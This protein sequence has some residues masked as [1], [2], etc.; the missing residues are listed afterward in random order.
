[1]TRKLRAALVARIQKHAIPPFTEVT[2]GQLLTDV[3]KLMEALNEQSTYPTLKLFCDWVVHAKL[4]GKKVQKLL[5]E[6]DSLYDSRLQH[7]IEINNDMPD[8]LHNFL[9]FQGFK[10]ELHVFLG[11]N[12]SVQTPNVLDKN[13]WGDF[14]ETYCSIVSDCLLIY[15][16]KK[17]PLK[18]FDRASISLRKLQFSPAQIKYDPITVSTGVQWIFFKGEKETFRLLLMWGSKPALRDGLLPHSAPQTP[19][20][21]PG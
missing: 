21:P 10:N 3:R 13:N 6:F 1:M 17:K 14:E 11:K 9:T 5:W 2:L 20:R 4:S 18:H 16:D 7:G 15:E 12:C 19:T 8:L